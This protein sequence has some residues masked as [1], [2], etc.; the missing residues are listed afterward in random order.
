MTASLQGSFL[1]AAIHLRDPNFFRSVVLILEHNSEGAMGLIV[2]RPSPMTI[3]GALSQYG[4]VECG[5]APVYVGGPV[6]PTSLYIL[7]NSVKLGQT[8]QEIAPGIFLTGS[9]DS[10]DQVVRSEKKSETAIKFRLLS[11]YSGWGGGQLESELDRGDW[12]TVP[13]DGPLILEEDP[14]GIWEIC[15][16]R[17]QRAN[18]M[19]PHLR[20]DY[21]QRPTRPLLST[22]RS[23]G[24]VIKLL[25]PS[26]DYSNEYNAWLHSIP[27]YVY[28]LVFI[29]KRFQKPEW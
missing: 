11:G 26:P 18:R 6:E 13:A 2:N 21:T 19:L 20:H 9:E 8:D 17:I 25:T 27:S 23:L 22:K 4:P 29:I 14:Y 10:F 5:E 12:H 15:T 28:A 7:H 16:R 24:S 3:A 1:V